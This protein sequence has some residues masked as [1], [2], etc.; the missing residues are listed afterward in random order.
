MRSVRPISRALLWAY[1]AAG[2]ADPAAA[3]ARL[4]LGRGSEA[5]LAGGIDYLDEEA[6]VFASLDIFVRDAD[7]SCGAPGATTLAIGHWPDQGWRY[8]QSVD[9]Q[10]L[11]GRHLDNWA[12]CWGD[13]GQNWNI[14][15]Y[16][17]AT[18]GTIGLTWDGA[19]RFEDE[20]LVSY[21]RLV[22]TLE[23]VTLARDEW[24]AGDGRIEGLVLPEA[25]MLVSQGYVD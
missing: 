2:C 6:T 20:Y 5:P 21:G 14:R 4:S 18:S 19:C 23:D 13:T 16:W 17:E 24:W 8:D 11:T 10:L 15:A 7:W 25:E 9:L 3:A 22:V 12:W 1:L